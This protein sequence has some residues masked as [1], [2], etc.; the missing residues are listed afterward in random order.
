MKCNNAILKFLE[1]KC[2]SYLQVLR[3][4]NVAKIWALAALKLRFSL[5][6]L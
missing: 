6:A 5:E 3:Y 4:L 1:F 2:V